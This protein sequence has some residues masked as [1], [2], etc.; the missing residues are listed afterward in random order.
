MI[1]ISPYV[2]PHYTDS[3]HASF[4]SV[5][6]FTERIFGIAPLGYTDYFSYGYMRM[7]D[8]SQKPLPPI[9]MVHSTVSTASLN[10]MATH[11]ADPN[12]PT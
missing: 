2:K 1:V 11:K 10:F 6:A 8:W 4:T 3:Y 9:T 7:F 5:T 12:D